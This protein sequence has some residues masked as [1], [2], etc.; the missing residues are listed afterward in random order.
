MRDV[1]R[2]LGCRRKLNNL[3]IRRCAVDFNRK[4]LN[5]FHRSAVEANRHGQCHLDHSLARVK[6]ESL[7][8]R[9]IAALSRRAD[10]KFDVR[11]REHV[12]HC[13][14]QQV[15]GKSACKLVQNA[16]WTKSAAC[17][18]SMRARKNDLGK[19]ASHDVT[20]RVQT[21]GQQPSSVASV[22]R[23]GARSDGVP[24]FV[25]NSI[26]RSL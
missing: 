10:V 24:S 3:Q 22:M 20:L 21:R 8:R 7:R 14:K 12:A 6:R 16:R 4:L 23:R 13:R 9:D 11:T 25:R 2:K 19:N 17:C 5:I 26:A 1:T 15:Y 18:N